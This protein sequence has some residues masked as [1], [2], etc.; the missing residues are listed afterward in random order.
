MTTEA[1][2]ITLNVG[3]HSAV[4][5]TRASTG[6]VASG[7][8]FMRE[9]GATITAAAA[10]DVI[11]MLPIFQN[12]KIVDIIVFANDVDD[13]TDGT[14]DVG[15][16]GGQ[17]GTSGYLTSNDDAYVDGDTCVQAGAIARMGSGIAGAA[18]DSVNKTFTE[19]ADENTKNF[20]VGTLAVSVKAG[21]INGGTITVRAFFAQV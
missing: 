17:S 6:A 11:H 7:S 21:A 8:I 13:N 2:T 10:D 1:V 5:S 14:I 16:I 19:K 3:T 12:E 15:F 4:D 18:V 20:R 9:A